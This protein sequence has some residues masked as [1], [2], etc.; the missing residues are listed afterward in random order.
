M[1]GNAVGNEQKS[2]SDRERANWIRNKRYEQV[3]VSQLKEVCPTRNSV[4]GPKHTHTRTKC[5][6]SH[7]KQPAKRASTTLRIARAAI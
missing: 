6:H 3:S 7:A 2:E 5:T 4:C 1:Q